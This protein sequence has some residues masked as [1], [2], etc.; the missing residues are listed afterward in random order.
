MHFIAISPQKIEISAKL[1]QDNAIDFTILSDVGNHIAQQYGLV[2]TLPQNVRELYQNLGADIPKF[3][4]DDSYQLPI[5]ATYLI[6][7][8][9][10]ILFSYINVNYMERVDISELVNVLKRN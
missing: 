8:D 7:Q 10:Q 2:F 1:Q 5:P 9:K 4:G 6:G 3:N